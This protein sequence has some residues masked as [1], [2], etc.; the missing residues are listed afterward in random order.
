[1]NTDPTYI[2]VD[3]GL[4][5]DRHIPFS[6]RGARVDKVQS[7]TVRNIDGEDALLFSVYDDFAPDVEVITAQQRWTELDG[8]DLVALGQWLNDRY[9]S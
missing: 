2:P 9:A 5:Q 6:E 3:Q 8:A 7:F 4:A 1:M